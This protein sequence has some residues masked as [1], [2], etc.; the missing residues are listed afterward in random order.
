MDIKP[1]SGVELKNTAASHGSS[2][3]EPSLLVRDD[4]VFIRMTPIERLQHI[5]LILCF[6]L[7]VL[8]GLPLL[9]D[10]AAWL[11]KAFFFETSF[12]WRGW[13]HRGRRRS[14]RAVSASPGL[15]QWY[16]KRPGTLLG[17]DAEA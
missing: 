16:A 1:L 4:E 5:T 14:D 7:L 10:P 11:K 13:I 12:A 6:V 2:Q 9:L 17:A 3:S 8:T 15:C